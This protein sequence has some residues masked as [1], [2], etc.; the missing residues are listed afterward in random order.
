MVREMLAVEVVT[1]GG[2]GPFLSWED[3]HQGALQGENPG[4]ASHMGCFHIMFWLG[5]GNGR[6]PGI[7][8]SGRPQQA[9]LGSTC[10]SCT[11]V[12]QEYSHSGF[13]A[14][15]CGLEQSMLKTLF[16]LCNIPQPLGSAVASAFSAFLKST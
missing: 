6:G 4:W 13:P 8:L 5:L 7:I 12:S 16:Q 15:S 11:A 10:G 9:A 3:C 14:L 1:E 2:S